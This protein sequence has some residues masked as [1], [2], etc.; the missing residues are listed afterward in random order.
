[1]ADQIVHTSRFLSL[2]LRHRPELVGLELDGEGWA[3]IEALLVGARK[4][5][6][7]I[8]LDELLEVVSQND[9][10]R[11]TISDDGL[12]IRANQGHTLRSV[13]LKLAVVT[14]PEILFHGTVEKYL[15]SIRRQG[16][17]KRKRNH[18]HLSGDH[19]TATKVGARRGAPIILRI[20]AGEMHRQGFE[21]FLS[22]NRVWL[23]EHVP[24]VFIEF[25]G[26]G[27]GQ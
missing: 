3:N 25:P 23:T 15:D 20:A 8:S 1:M 9:K 11:F 6:R 26:S 7:D 16:L 12:H 14:P 10:Q 18:V 2:V 24:L 5:G 22:E 17:H 4:C 13:D 21:F 27:N 19:A